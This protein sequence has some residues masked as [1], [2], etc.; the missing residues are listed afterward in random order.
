MARNFQLVSALLA[1][2]A[3]A[4]VASADVSNQIYA[5]DQTASPSQT[6]TIPIKMK[7]SVDATAYSFS[8]KLPDGVDP[9]KVAL[10]KSTARKT[11]NVVFDHAVQSDNSIMALCYTTDGEKF[12]GNDGEVATVSFDVPATMATGNY[13]I[14]IKES[15]ISE[16][17]IAHLVN[18][19]VS[20]K[21]IVSSALVEIDLPD[22]VE[23]NNEDN[24][25]VSKVTYTRTWGTREQW[26][27]LCIPFRFEV[28]DY[29]EDLDV[30]EI[31]AVCPVKDTNV[32]GTI[33]SKD[34]NFMI[35]SLVTS[36]LTYP[37]APYLVRPKKVDNP[38]VTI[39]ATNCTL[40]AATC[41][42]SIEFST[43]R[44]NYSITGLYKTFTVKNG[45]HNY[46]ID[47]YGRLN[48]AAVSANVDIKANR[49]IMNATPKN[50]VDGY[51]EEVSTLPKQM[52]IV[53]LGEDIDEET[54]LQFIQADAI[55][56]CSGT[57]IIY[58]INGVRVEDTNAL[59]AGIYVKNGKTFMIR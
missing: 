10:A 7:N 19:P 54:A 30:A 29:A 52:R 18:E 36:G 25:V 28:S 35:V 2:S 34:D 37:S 16:S 53:V 21:L 8:I 3:C 50:Y 14:V 45:D 1:L 6:V 43:S 33:D 15:E 42:N 49:W 17:G 31:F 4:Q 40:Y 32:D 22:G 11:N 47:K 48:Q 23:Y 39:S 55:Q 41:L 13:D 38:K 9:E 5:V 59:P 27:P 56:N 12:S 57:D 51:D 46:Y 58:N 20:S 24:I 26:Y 44:M